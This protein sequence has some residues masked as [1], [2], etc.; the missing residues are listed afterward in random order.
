MKSI[1]NY[2]L[3]LIIYL[4]PILLFFIFV[5]YTNYFLDYLNVFQKP[6]H[7][8]DAIIVLGGGVAGNKI[9][10]NTA[11]RVRWALFL[12]QKNYADTLILSGGFSNKNSFSEAKVMYKYLKNYNISDYNVILEEKSNNTFT[13]FVETEKIII[14]N[15]LKNVVLITNPPHIYR[16]YMTFKNSSANVIP[17]SVPF[18]SYKFYNEKIKL[19]FVI[20]ELAAVLSYKWK[21]DL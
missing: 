21:Y 3:L 6:V 1:I 5:D 8:I 4:I 15:N 13:N 16:A 9:N 12:L 11:E 17:V 7:D 14:E 10:R 2:C 19:R 20:Y 18:S